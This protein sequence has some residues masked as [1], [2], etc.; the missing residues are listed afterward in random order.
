MSGPASAVF[1]VTIL[2]GAAAW[3]ADAQKLSMAEGPSFRADA[4]LVLVPVAVMDRRGAVVN[5]LAR[6][7]FTLTEDGVRQQIRSFSEED[8]PVSIGT[9]LDL[10]GSMRATLGVAKE[11]LRTLMKDVNPAD[12]AFLNTVSTHPREYSEFT[13]DFDA[14]LSRVAFESAGGDTALIDTIYGS[15]K[16]LRSG[17]HARKALLIISDGMD[18]HSRYSRGE[19]LERAMESDAQ[20]YTIAVGN[21][22]AYAKPMQVMEEKRGLLFLDELAAKTGGISFAV[23]GG[24]EVADAAAKIGQALRNQYVIG[25]APRGD[26]RGGRWHRITVKVAGPGTRAYAREGYRLD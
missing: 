7:A 23:R 6:D 1:A 26:D 4:T 14:V 17:I 19:L 10:S 5:G 25:Y 8:A 16:E 15:L 18:N 21:A 3:F 12:E 24:K 9:V 13:N 22:P 20:I 11:A 2:L